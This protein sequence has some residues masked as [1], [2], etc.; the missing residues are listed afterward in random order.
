MIPMCQAMLGEIQQE[1]ATTRRLLE[2]VPENKLLGSL[3]RS[4]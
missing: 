4:R 3:T 1:A 2:R